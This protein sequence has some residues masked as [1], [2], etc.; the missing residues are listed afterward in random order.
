MIGMPLTILLGLGLALAIPL[1]LGFWEA[2]LLAAIL[3]PTDAALGQTVVASPL[4]PPRIRQALNVEASAVVSNLDPKRTFLSM[5]DPADLADDFRRRVEK[6]IT[7]VSCYKLLA[8]IDELPEWTAW[9]G[10]AHRPHAGSVIIG[11]ASRA[12]VAAAHDDCEAGRPP[13]AAIISLSVPSV[14]DP[15]VTQGGCHTASAWIFP[16]PARLAEGSWEDVRDRVADRL[17]DQITEYAPNFRDS[18]RHFKLRTP[19]DLERDNGLTDG[20][21]WHVQHAG[22]Q[23]FWNRPLPELSAY[24]APLRGLYLCGAGQHPGG[25]VTG[26]P[27][28]NAAHE[29]LDDWSH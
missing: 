18:I 14:S 21:I 26:M 22:E 29:L 19:L 12:E 9:D 2:A 27:G 3:A 25:E 8:V 5:I 16:A 1:G 15:T 24:R 6:L 17:I 20:C 7:N 11:G 13:R 28:H 10:D 23:L 4:V